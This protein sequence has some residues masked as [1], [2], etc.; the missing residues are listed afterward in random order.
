M[1]DI[2]DVVDDVFAQL[3]AEESAD[4]FMQLR[5][6]Y[7]ASKN[8]AMFDRLTLKLKQRLRYEPIHGLPLAAQQSLLRLAFRNE[9]LVWM[10]RGGRPGNETVQHYL[11]F[12]QKGL[13]G[14]AVFDG[15]TVVGY[16]LGEFTGGGEYEVVTAWTHSRYQGMGVA[17]RQYFALLALVYERGAKVL[18]MDVVVGG[19]DRA[20]RAS[21]PLRV[22]RR[23]VL[24]SQQTSY[25]TDKEQF[26]TV[27]LYV[28]TL[29]WIVRL[30]QVLSWL[31]GTK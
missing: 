24:H 13:P 6:Y 21:W 30:Y 16:T 3:A 18:H 17:L 8:E 31:F 26:E 20:A 5:E 27:R 14:V 19:L 29:Y 12:A 10:L 4:L 7:R 22:G 28:R 23:L 9:G 25:K 11:Q 15:E 1:A 2:V